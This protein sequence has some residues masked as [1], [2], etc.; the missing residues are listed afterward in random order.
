MR[1]TS[2]HAH[3]I[4]QRLAKWVELLRYEDLPEGVIEI[5]KAANS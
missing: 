3:T 1:V 4:S 2:E 5:N